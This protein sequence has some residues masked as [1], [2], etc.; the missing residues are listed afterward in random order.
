[1]KQTMMIKRSA[2]NHNLY[3]LRI[4]LKRPKRQRIMI[5]QMKDNNLN[6]SMRKQKNGHLGLLKKS[7]KNNY[8]RMKI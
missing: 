7:R 2:L 6:I 1:M 4:K 5:N 3:I 8:K